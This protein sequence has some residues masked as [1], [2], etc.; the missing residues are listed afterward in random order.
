MELEYVIQLSSSSDFATFDAKA[1][2][3]HIF[4]LKG[5]NETNR[6]GYLSSRI[7]VI[8]RIAARLPAYLL[9]SM[10][11]KV[12]SKNVCIQLCCLIVVAVSMFA[13]LNDQCSA[14]ARDERDPPSQPIHSCL[15]S[16][17]TVFRTSSD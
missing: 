7:A 4:D 8:T 3:I 1:N 6:K 11:K 12:L 16:C 9:N 15:Y 13:K 10:N 2:A 17:Q 5:Q 14:Y